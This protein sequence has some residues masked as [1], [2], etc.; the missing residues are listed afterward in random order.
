MRDDTYD[1]TV[2]GNPYTKMQP[3]DATV[4]IFWLFGEEGEGPA[5]MVTQKAADP[6]QH[7][8]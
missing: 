1:E 2:N 7:L 6:T 4:Y 3:D 5:D 8:H